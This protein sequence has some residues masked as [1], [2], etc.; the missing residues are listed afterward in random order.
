MRTLR[1][2]FLL[3]LLIAACG[4]DRAAAPPP[5][6]ADPVAARGQAV[7]GAFKTRIRGALSK[8]LEGGTPSAI[9]VCGDAAKDAAAAVAVDGVTVGR[10]TRKP[11]NPANAVTGWQ[12]EALAEFE[13][14]AAAGKPLDGARY[15]KSMP[16]GRTRYA[17]P[18]VVQALCTKCHGAA[19][20]PDVKAALATA[21][22]TDQATGYREGDLRGLAWAEF[23]TPAR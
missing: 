19:L 3:G 23:A 11:R 17:E 6:S 18:L 22:P 15:V 2:W 5:T 12:A 16:D 1:S 20:E 14:L 10:A 13:A 21:Y 7:V 4:K 9:S 8:A